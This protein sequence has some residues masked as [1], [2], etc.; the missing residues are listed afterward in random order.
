MPIKIVMGTAASGK[1]HFIKTHFPEYEHLDVLDYQN[2]V[3]KKYGDLDSVDFET[4][5]MA[6]AEA[7]ERIKEDLVKAVSEHKLVV[8]EH[9][10]FKAKRRIVYV[11]ALREVTDEP[12]EIYV[13][14]P[15][16]ERLKDNI[17]QREE[18][19]ER[20]FY[21]LKGEWEQIELPNIS[22][23]FSKIY[24][25][26]DDVIEEYIAPARPE[27]IAPAKEEIRLEQEEIKSKKEKE[28]KFKCAVERTKTEP[29]LHYCE[30]CGKQEYLTSKEAFSKSWDYPGADGIYK[31]RKNYGFA[32]FLPRTCG[33][34]SMTD[35]FYWKLA[36]GN[37]TEEGVTER[38]KETLKRI[39]KEPFNLLKN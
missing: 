16:D 19:D 33:D 26:R 27:I 29:F 30:V 8:M 18:L 32:M 14:A 9:T 11:E 25:V 24:L 13:M 28:E 22:E 37:K 21:R 15:S 35:T 4:Y 12:V 20:S 3:K 5:R 36:L 6:L 34:C 17:R 1:S 2:E 39:Q 10:L 7:N 23:G 38:N 31:K